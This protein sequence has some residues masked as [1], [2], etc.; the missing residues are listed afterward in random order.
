MS[1][2]TSLSFGD[3]MSD[4]KSTVLITGGTSGLG[5]ETATQIARAHP[6]RLVVITGRSPR[7][8]E[9]AINQ[10][11]GHK[12]VVFMPLDLSSE[13][14]V[15]DFVDR[16]EK[17][18]HPPIDALILNA[19]IQFTDGLHMNADGLEESFAVNHLNNALVFFLLKHRLSHSARILTIGSKLH[20]PHYKRMPLDAIWTSAEDAA[21][22]TPQKETNLRNEGFRRYGLSKAANILFIYALADEIRSQGKGWVT[23]ALDPGVM[24]TNLFRS[25]GPVLGTL[26][27]GALRSP[28][29]KRVAPDAVPIA[30]SAGHLVKM[31][32]HPSFGGDRVN[33]KYYDNHGREMKSSDASYV[34]RNQ[35]DLWEWTLNRLAKTAE[36]KTQ[37]SIL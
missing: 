8:V 7:G 5:Q 23:M 27:K 3:N 29:G 4:F 28:I 18:P 12:N 13:A 26:A 32:T 31:A 20:D 25:L 6:D 34:T 16:Y 19:A 1:A 9:K 10:Q 24:P 2:S 17:R 11:T 21:R 30:V 15:R 36:E 33:G 22:P 14:G 37:F 35:Q